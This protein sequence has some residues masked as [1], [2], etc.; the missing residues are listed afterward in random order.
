MRGWPL[1]YLLVIRPVR[2]LI[3]DM[4]FLS[5]LSQPLVPHAS[6]I[7]GLLVITPAL[8]LPL[9]PCTNLVTTHGVYVAWVNVQASIMLPNIFN[10]PRSTSRA[11]R[12]S[13]PWFFGH[14]SPMA[15]FQG[16]LY[17]IWKTWFG[18]GGVILFWLAA[19]RFASRTIVFE[20]TYPSRVILVTLSTMALDLRRGIDHLNGWVDPR[21]GHSSSPVPP[22]G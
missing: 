16:K 11:P 21:V 12:G 14:P 10:S 18:W 15:V 5:I 1:W 2:A 8:S 19:Y 22:M 13:R 17:Y 20:E 3:Q 6:L 4:L 9:I 7:T